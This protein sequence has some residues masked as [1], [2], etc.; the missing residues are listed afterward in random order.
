MDEGHLTI[1]TITAL[2]R[3]LRDTAFADR[4]RRLTEYLWAALVPQSQPRRPRHHRRENPPPRSARQPHSL[5]PGPALSRDVLVTPPSSPPIPPSRS[6]RPPYAALATLGMGDSCC[7]STPIARQP[8]SRCS[9]SST[10]LPPQSPTAATRARPART[11]HSFAAPRP[12]GPTA[13][14]PLPPAPSSSPV[15]LV[16]I[17]MAEPHLLGRH[18]AF[19][20][21]DEAPAAQRLATQLASIAPAAE[22]HA[23]TEQA[24]AAVADQLAACSDDLTPD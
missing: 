23:R 13:G 4:A 20:P 5:G 10:A 7:C 14:R 21:G 16:T 2:V 17:P 24:C 19:P 22:L 1:A 3:Q 15:G 9:R 8:P 18:P 11:R 12:P 6:R